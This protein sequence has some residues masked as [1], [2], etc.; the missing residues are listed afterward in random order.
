MNELEI[1]DLLSCVKNLHI[2]A[3]NELKFS[4]K[5]PS[6]YVV[7]TGNRTLNGT[8]SGEHWIGL[9]FDIVAGQNTCFLFDSLAAYPEV[10]CPEIIG[11]ALAHS[12]VQRINGRRIQSPYNRTCGLHVCKFVLSYRKKYNYQLFLKSFSTNEHTN[13]INVLKLFEKS[14][15]VAPFNKKSVKMMCCQSIKAHAFR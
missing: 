15:Q 1:E 11:F 10:T 9:I 3:K 13:D 4:S 12:S 7:N 2:C 8:N 14:L 5:Y 6:Y